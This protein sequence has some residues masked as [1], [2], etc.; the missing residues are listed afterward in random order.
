[1]KRLQIFLPVLIVILI[2]NGLIGCGGGESQP[3]KEVIHWTKINSG[4]TENLKAI[5]DYINTN[6]VFIVGDHGT[7]IHGQFDTNTWQL[8]TSPTTKNL[9]G[10]CAANS[11]FYAVGDYDGDHHTILQYNGTQCLSVPNPSSSITSNLYAID[12]TGTSLI[13]V[14]NN[15]CG[16]YRDDTWLF[17]EAP[18]TEYRGV[19]YD[20]VGD[21]VAVGLYSNG[22]VT[23][24]VFVDKGFGWNP[25]YTSP[26]NTQKLNAVVRGSNYLCVGD[27]G[28]IIKL[29]YSANFVSKIES[30]TTEN[31]N[32]VS[33]I[34]DNFSIAVGNNGT[35]IYHDGKVCSKSASGVSENLNGVTVFSPSRI[36]AVGNNG[37]ILWGEMEYE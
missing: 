16:T 11:G 10:I 27:N 32:G 34:G 31:L 24:N 26:Y 28:L 4:T 19:Q 25:G 2:A 22:G 20:S 21:I 30:G 6:E 5:S 12:S 8:I 23:N 7:I 13:V 29:D 1:M 37:V 33:S 14:G 36:I 15:I 17:K 9:N 3:T 18:A 35:I